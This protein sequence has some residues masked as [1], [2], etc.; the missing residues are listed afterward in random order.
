MV[1]DIGQRVDL[2]GKPALLLERAGN[3]DVLFHRVARGD[4]AP[5]RSLKRTFRS[6]RAVDGESIAHSPYGRKGAKWRNA[7]SIYLRRFVMSMCLVSSPKCGKI[8]VKSEAHCKMARK[9]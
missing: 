8:F 5:L 1:D 2:T 6:R 9:K 3:R 7:S 4:P